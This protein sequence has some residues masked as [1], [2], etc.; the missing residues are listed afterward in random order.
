MPVPTNLENS[1]FYTDVN[2][3]SHTGRQL[4]HKLIADNNIT[5]GKNGTEGTI[6]VFTRSH[7]CITGDNWLNGN[8]CCVDY[9]EI[10]SAKMS[11][12]KFS[13]IFLRQ[14]KREQSW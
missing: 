1:M 6:C 13:Y 4:I 12:Y 7:P 2:D 5:N 3:N 8:I 10:I 14:Q 9:Y 11:K